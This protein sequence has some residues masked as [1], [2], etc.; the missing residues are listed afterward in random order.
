MTAALDLQAPVVTATDLHG[1]LCRELG[2]RVH[3]RDFD[4]HIRVE[5]RGQGG[6]DHDYLGEAVEAWLV[7]LDPDQRSGDPSL[8]LVSG[9]ASITLRAVGK[10]QLL[11]GRG[12]LV[13][14]RI[15]GFPERCR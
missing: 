5:S 4:L 8:T 2:Q 14:N 6:I 15:S 1:E 9:L 11:R 13:A 7:S 3:N 12:R 10:P